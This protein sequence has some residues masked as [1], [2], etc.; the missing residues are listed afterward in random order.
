[1]LVLKIITSLNIM[2]IS[3]FL[4][5]SSVTA[6]DNTE[7]LLPFDFDELNVTRTGWPN[8]GLFN[9]TKTKSKINE[10]IIGEWI[11]KIRPTGLSEKLDSQYYDRIKITEDI[12]QATRSYADGTFATITT[13]RYAVFFDM[14]N[15]GYVIFFAPRSSRH[16]VKVT[17]ALFLNKLY[18]N[19]EKLHQKPAQLNTLKIRQ[20]ERSERGPLVEY[21]RETDIK[22]EAGSL[23]ESKHD[24]G[25]M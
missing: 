6:M 4:L 13:V 7:P 16:S 14:Q 12:I 23:P 11:L 5:C 17:D 18:V 10:A 22:K 19:V 20:W 21:V 25:N 15:G 8:E 9:I 24:T 2:Y 3:F 1:M